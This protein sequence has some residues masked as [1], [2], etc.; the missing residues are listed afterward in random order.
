MD[1]VSIDKGEFSGVINY[2][3]GPLITYD[4]LQIRGDLKIKPQFLS[5]YLQVRPGTP[6]SQKRSNRMEGRLRGL[7][8]LKMNSP[9]TTSFQNLK[10]TH[11]LDLSYQRVN[12][13]DGI[14]GF[15]PNEKEGNKLLVTGEF[16]LG[17]HN[18]FQSGKSL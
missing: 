9:V 14:I 6:Y 16:N 3:P 11:Y 8:Y 4:T 17:L 5:A 10:S 13:V 12:Q 18:L 1:S 15:L 7:S 2:E